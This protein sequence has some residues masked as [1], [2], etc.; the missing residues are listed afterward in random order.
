MRA[1]SH[2]VVPGVWAMV[3]F[4]GET[5]ELED[6]RNWTDASFKTYS[7][8]LRLPFPARVEA[9][10]RIAQSITL[11]LKD[12]RRLPLNEG[13]LWAKGSA[14]DER[15]VSFV[16][17]PSPAAP[18]PRI[19]L[20]V[21]SHGRPLT[22]K[23][24]ARLKALNLAHLRVD[25]DLSRPEYPSELRRAADEGRALGARLEVA[26]MLSNAAVSELAALRG[27]LE[28]VQPDV[29]A[30]LI[31]HIAEKSTSE[32]WVQ[33]ARESLTHY[34]PAAT[35]G[36]GT[37][38]YFAELNRARPP[39]RALDLVSYSINPQ[40]H[41]FDNASLVETLAAPAATGEI[42]RPFMGG[43]PRGI[44]PGSI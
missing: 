1:L 11:T 36:A 25:L 17:R 39:L 32:Q 24:T 4:D 34:D 8:P 35:I 9:G 43:R 33:L 22:A 30:W 23:E 12:E 13:A 21:A 2:E 14:T 38:S 15:G 27:V 29:G 19:G 41:A 5:F 6:Q 44:S 40:V 20:G 28:Q 37:N 7:T 26:L 18:L 16:L 31:F 3:R 10:T 42:A